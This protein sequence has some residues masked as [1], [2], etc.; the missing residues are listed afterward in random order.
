[1]GTNHLV[2][3]IVMI[4]VSKF[5]II[6][7]PLMVMI[8]TCEP[9]QIITFLMSLTSFMMRMTIKVYILLLLMSITSSM[10]VMMPVSVTIEIL[11]VL[12]SIISLIMR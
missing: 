6:I 12:M 5:L 2:L 4:P 1:M 8:M 3:A 7:P 9:V 10:M 11:K